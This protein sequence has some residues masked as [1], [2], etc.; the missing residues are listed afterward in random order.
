M[1]KK[2]CIFAKNFKNAYETLYF[3]YFSLFGM[4]YYS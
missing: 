2:S 4:R 3:A 1:S